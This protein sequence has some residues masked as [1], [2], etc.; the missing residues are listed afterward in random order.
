MSK[1]MTALYERTGIHD[2]EYVR[3]Q[4]NN[5]ETYAASNDFMN[6]QHFTDDGYSAND[7]LLRFLILSCLCKWGTKP[8]F[9]TFHYLLLT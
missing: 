4:R 9:H 7:Y 5:L 1:K 6:L 8:I 2:P 3:R